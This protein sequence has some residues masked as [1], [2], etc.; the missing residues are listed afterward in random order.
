MR[1]S[2]FELYML[3]KV[4]VLTNANKNTKVELM[5]SKQERSNEEVIS[6]AIT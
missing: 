4:N 5:F 1:K 3:A 2:Q 6:E